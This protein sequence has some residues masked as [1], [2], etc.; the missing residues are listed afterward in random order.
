MKNKILIF[1]SIFIFQVV[2]CQKD[3]KMIME[4]GSKNAE[5]NSL[6]SFQNIAVEN[7]SFESPEIK[8]KFYEVNLNEYKKGKLIKTKN[9]IDL[10]IVDYLKID[11]TFTSFKFFSKIENDKIIFYIQSLYISSENMTFNLEKGKGSKYVL[12]DFLVT[13]GFTYVPIDKEFPI[14]AI[15]TPVKINERESSYCE[16]AQSGVEPDKYWEKFKIP[17]YFVIT[18]KFK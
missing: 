8:G 12:K 17:H 4:Y 2:Y 6:M 7:I 3:I 1:L 5:I 18:M 13:D 15:I 9:L 11:S 16:V 14:L 10:N